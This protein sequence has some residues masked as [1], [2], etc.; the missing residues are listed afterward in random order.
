MA[1]KTSYEVNKRYHDKAMK[2]YTIRFHRTSDSDVIS[3]I[4]SSCNKTDFIRRCIRASVE[5]EST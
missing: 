2:Q 5:K 1:A 3:A 4:D